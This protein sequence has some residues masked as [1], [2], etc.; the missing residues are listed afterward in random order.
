MPSQAG[1]H[2]VVIGGSMAG[3]MA[4]RVLADHFERV[5]VVEKD[6]IEAGPVLHKSIPQGNHYHAL[7]LGGLR[8]L[9]SLLPGFALRLRGLGAVPVR[10]GAEVA[11]HLPTGKF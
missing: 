2:A 1:D 11:F 3:L 8:G 5:T 4:A 7:L 6:A 9:E 10:A